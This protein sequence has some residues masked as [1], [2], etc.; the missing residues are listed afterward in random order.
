MLKTPLC[1]LPGIDVSITWRRWDVYIGRVAA[2]VSNNGSLGG[3]GALFRTAAPIKRDIGVVRKLT[4]RPV[5]DQSHPA[6][7]G[8]GGV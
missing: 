6:E 5:R 3:V 4:A 2:A 7:S 1:N 8:C